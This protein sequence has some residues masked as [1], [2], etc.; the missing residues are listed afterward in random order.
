MIKRLLIAL[1][2]L[3]VVFSTVSCGEDTESFAC[4]ELTL[5]MPSDFYEAED[6][7]YDMLLTNGRATAAVTRI[8]FLA[9]MQ[10]GIPETYTDGE[11]AE[12]FMNKTGADSTVYVY[13]DTP[14]YT[15]NYVAGTTSVFCTAAFYKTPYAYFF[16][17]FSTPSAYE[18]EWREK[19]LEIADSVIFNLT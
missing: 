11:F 18:D 9:A 5:V 15:Y 19:F 3:S 8:S 6:D 14:Y 12:F 1:L 13:G 4:S 10:Q 17:L 7:E 2:T 16:V